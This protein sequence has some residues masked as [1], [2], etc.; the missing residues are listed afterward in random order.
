MSVHFGHFNQRGMIYWLGVAND[1]KMIMILCHTAQRPA[2]KF[3]NPVDHLMQLIDRLF[4]L[5]FLISLLSYSKRNLLKKDASVHLFRKSAILKGTLSFFS[6]I[7][8]TFPRNF[9]KGAE[10]SLKISILCIRTAWI[11]HM[12]EHHTHSHLQAIMS[13]QS[14]EAEFL[15][16]PGECCWRKMTWTQMKDMKTLRLK[17][18]FGIKAYNVPASNT[19]LTWWPQSWFNSFH[20]IFRQQRNKMQM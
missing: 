14:R 3:R 1:G 5:L 18:T 13:L 4:L 15:W 20:Q 12:Q 8:G 19:Q 11:I 7:S 17:S 10:L 6:R 9:L 16:T 2:W